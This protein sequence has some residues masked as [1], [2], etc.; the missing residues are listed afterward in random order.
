MRQISYRFTIFLSCLLLSFSAKAQLGGQGVYSFLD[1]PISARATS[2]GGAAYSAP[3]GDIALAG[4]NPILLGS[5]THQKVSFQTGFYLANTNYGSLIY[6][7]HSQ[8]LK[9][10]FSTSVSY[11]TYGKFDGRDP[12]GNHIGNFRAGGVYMAGAAA[13]DWKNFSY[14]AQLKMIFSGIERYN[15][16]GL[17]LDL[18]AGYLNED[19]NLVLSLMLRN[20]GGELKPFVPGQSRENLPLDLSFSLSKRFDKLP[21]RLMLQAHHLQKW[22]LTR[23]KPNKNNQQILNTQSMVERGVMD[24]LFAHIVAGVEVEVAQV[25]SLRVGYDHLR[26][27]ELTA[28]DKKGLVGLSGGLGLT[29]QQFQIDYGFAKYHAVGSLNHVGITINI[30]EWGNR[31]N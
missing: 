9:T 4:G 8:K 25:V 22:D 7:H 21:L 28:G 12:A 6:G 10:N 18:S 14:G 5:E 24:K 3:R 16:L 29:I 27:M 19:R 31:A 20:I 13:R 17:G 30:Q 11:I 15:S 23:P 2:L 26:R 1:M